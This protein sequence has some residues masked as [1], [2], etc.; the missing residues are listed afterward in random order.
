MLI[1]HGGDYNLT[2]ADGHTS[3][4][5]AAMEGYT[6]CALAH[7][8]SAVGRDILSLPSRVSGDT[9]LHECVKHGMR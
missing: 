6:D 7:L 2:D 4:Y 8:D 9:P 5:V 1:L 3:M